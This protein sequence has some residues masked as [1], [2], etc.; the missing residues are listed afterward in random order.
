MMRPT[1]FWQRPVLQR[2]RQHITQVGRVAARHPELVQSARNAPA[3]ELLPEG[4]DQDVASVLFQQGVDVRP[5]A[6]DYPD[7]VLDMADDWFNDRFGG[8]HQ[9]ASVDPLKAI[10]EYRKLCDEIVRRDN[11]GML[12][13]LKRSLY[14]G[15][16]RAAPS[17]EDDG[18]QRP[19]DGSRDREGGQQREADPSTTESASQPDVV[20]APGAA[21]PYSPLTLSR[22]TFKPHGPPDLQ[23]ADSLIKTAWSGDAQ[24]AE[25]L[26]S[27]GADPN[28]RCDADT[29]A[30]SYAARGGHAEV[31]RLLLA[32]G[33]SP[34]SQPQAPSLH[35][36][37]ALG[38]VDL[39][40]M[41]LDAGADPDAQDELGFTAVTHAACWDQAETAYVLVENGAD[42]DAR[43]VVGRTPLAH[44][45]CH[46][47][48]RVAKVLIELG[49]D[50]DAEDS[51]KG[52]HSPVF[53]TAQWD[54]IDVLRLLVSAG[55][56]VNATAGGEYTPLGIAIDHDY[57]EVACL[58]VAAGARLAGD[59]FFSAPTAL[60]QAAGRGN[61]RVVRALVEAGAPINARDAEGQTALH[62][63]GSS[64]D[65]LGGKLEICRCLLSV[66]AHVDA[67]DVNGWTPLHHAACHGNVEVAE[68]LLRAGADPMIRATRPK[69]ET[70]RQ[71]TKLDESGRAIA[72]MIDRRLHGSHP[73]GAGQQ[74][75]RGSSE[76]KPT[77]KGAS[78]GCCLAAC[79]LLVLAAG[80]TILH[81]WVLALE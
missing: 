77:G 28:A 21:P 46:N 13:D 18:D 8:Y 48:A 19:D 3:Q 14:S 20:W 16:D 53:C 39:V 59:G 50:V 65:L 41:L 7:W 24:T 27:C 17:Q 2:V 76:Q 58:I 79:I 36:P 51:S 26:L 52:R 38:R 69:G 60:Y 81:S 35:A 11:E 47:N 4:L 42:I 12:A 40:R 31:V 75:T 67:Q 73:H 9:M 23:Q 33:A 54:S 44:A 63:V 80:S 74:N 25:E 57:T 15:V 29:P 71:F 32:A 62:L 5:E 10:Q 6:Y 56:D 37:A 78:T 34:D 45:A 55:A 72:E 66:G 70:A 49:A 68:L 64:S 1:P 61:A 22:T 30:L 43:D